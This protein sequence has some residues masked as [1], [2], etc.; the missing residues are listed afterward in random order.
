GANLMTCLMKGQIPVSVTAVTRHFKP[1]KYPKVEDEATIIVTYSEAQCIIQAS[2]NWPFSRKDMEIYG[3]TGYVIS[4]N[5]SI[6]RIR[7][8]NMDA[9]QTMNVS[10]NDIKVYEDPFSYFVDVIHGTVKMKNYDLYALENNVIVVKILDAA[11][12]SAETGRTVK[13]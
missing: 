6:M 5:N 2:W 13:L 7:N 1:Q 10:A 4:V 9:E 8:K 12:K 11:K 3:E